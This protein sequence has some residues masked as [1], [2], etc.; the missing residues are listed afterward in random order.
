ML[1][2]NVLQINNFSNINYLQTYMNEHNIDTIEL[3]EINNLDTLINILNFKL[4]KLIINN[5]NKNNVPILFKCNKSIEF[6]ELKNTKQEVIN[7]IYNY[8]LLDKYLQV[9]ITLINNALNLHFMI[10]SK[11]I[12][13][14]I[15][16]IAN[17][18]IK[19]I[20]NEIIKDYKNEM[21]E[22]DETEMDEIEKMDETNC[23]I[24]DCNIFIKYM[25]LIYLDI[26]RITNNIINKHK[27]TTY[28]KQC[29]N[30]LFMYGNLIIEYWN[31]NKNEIC[32]GNQFKNKYIT[33]T[34][35]I[36]YII[37]NKGET[38]N[39]FSNYDF[40]SMMINREKSYYDINLYEYLNLENHINENLY[41]LNNNNFM[42]CII[43]FLIN[44]YLY[45]TSLLKI[46]QN[47]EFKKYL[48][49][50]V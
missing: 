32:N 23:E 39:I 5:I 43:L 40:I 13:L 38:I 48:N 42:K 17:L 1:K 7:M 22:V 16:D 46:E 45:C 3:T 10:N 33:L 36:Y 9:N 30:I 47:K 12:G 26:A 37:N 4:N 15:S 29:Y 28:D 35:I 24:N 34:N 14:L 2:N 19:D 21:L 8:V 27:F 25:N 41:H 44:K 6:I 31:I 49:D 11:N 20:E 18:S 50:Y